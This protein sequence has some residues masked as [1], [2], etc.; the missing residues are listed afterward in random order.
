MC[1]SKVRHS[2][3]SGAYYVCA[4]QPFYDDVAAKDPQHE[5]NQAS[6]KLPSGLSSVSPNVYTANCIIPG[7]KQVRLFS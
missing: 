1:T 6:G 4:S 7:Y 3:P 5:L 2:I